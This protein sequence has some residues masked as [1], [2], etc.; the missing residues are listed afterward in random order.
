MVKRYALG[1]PLAN[2]VIILVWTVA[3]YL[4]KAS[5]HWDDPNAGPI[6]VSYLIFMAFLLGGFAVVGV[7]S[8]WNFIPKGAG[9]GWGAVFGFTALTLVLVALV[10]ERTILGR[11][12]ILPALEQGGGFLVGC[13]LKKA[14]LHVS[15]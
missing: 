6:S 4:E 3:C 14:V 5:G 2:L 15:S 8:G 13:C 11:S 12:A 10:Y 9:T 1:I 7:V